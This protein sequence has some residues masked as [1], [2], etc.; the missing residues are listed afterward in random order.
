MTTL[1]TTPFSQELALFNIIDVDGKELVTEFEGDVLGT[2]G[3]SCCH[4]GF[5]PMAVFVSS[6]AFEFIVVG[7]KRPKGVGV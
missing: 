5:T 6:F 4:V 2:F 7:V 1:V 3:N